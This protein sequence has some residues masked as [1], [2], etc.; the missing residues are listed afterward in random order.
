[1]VWSMRS[2]CNVHVVFVVIVSFSLFGRSLTNNIDQL[3]KDMEQAKQRLQ[4]LND[5]LGEF[6]LLLYCRRR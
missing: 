4:L 2:V 6:D 5:K 1:M 3:K